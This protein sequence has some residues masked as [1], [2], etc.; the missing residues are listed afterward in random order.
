MMQKQQDMFSPELPDLL[1]V[2]ALGGSLEEQFWAFHTRNPHVYDAMVSVAMGMRRAGWQR[3]AIKMII[4]RLRW[5][6]ALKTQG[7]TYKL[8]NNHA[9][10]YA[11]LIMDTVPE[12][13][14]FFELREQR[15]GRAS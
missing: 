14:G 4:E 9:P 5:L 12:L 7:S 15:T 10:F 6:H 3:G 2:E 8:N 1:P 11:R 13:A